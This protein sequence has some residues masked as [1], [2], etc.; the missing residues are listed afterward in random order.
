M[1]QRTA[2]ERMGL[3]DKALDEY[4]QQSHLPSLTAP[5]KESELGEYLSMSRNIIEK[6]TTDECGRISY[7]LSQ[8][9]FYIQRLYNREQA[10]MI[11]AKDRLNQEIAK[12]VGNYDKYTKHEVKVALLIAENTYADSLNSIIIYA[13]Q[14]SARLKELAGELKHMSNVMRNLSYCQK[15]EA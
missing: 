6:F 14:R 8:F 9:S 4:E 1:E 2:K 7:R 12:A 13:E 5:G 15:P 3:V 11:W 10:R